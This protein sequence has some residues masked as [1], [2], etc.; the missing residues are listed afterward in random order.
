MGSDSVYTVVAERSSGVD[1]RVSAFDP[2]ASTVASNTVPSVV[3][4]SPRSESHPSTSRAK[5]SVKS[6]RASARESF[7]S[8]SSDC[9]SHT[10]S[11]NITPVKAK[12][13]FD[14]RESSHSPLKRKRHSHSRVRS[15]LSDMSVVD[16]PSDVGDISRRRR[17]SVSNDKRTRVEVSRGLFRNRRSGSPEIDTDGLPRYKRDNGILT[18][19][20]SRGRK[21]RPS[22]DGEREGDSHHF[23]RKTFGARVVI[24]IGRA[25]CRERV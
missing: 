10:S 5:V 18:G 23:R 11:C 17:S 15:K 22:H 25:S 9:T 24:E 8:Y 19:A 13:R 7:R 6:F 3:S 14:N 16:D 2:K 20:K 1:E 12:K 21:S 4:V